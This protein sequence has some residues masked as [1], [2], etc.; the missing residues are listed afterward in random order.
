MKN[1]IVVD[2]NNL[3]NYKLKIITLSPVHIGTGEVYEPTNYIVDDKKLYKFDEIL[4]YKS[5]TKSDKKSFYNKLSNYMQVIDFYKS[6]KEEAK[7]IANFEIITSSKVQNQY[8]KQTNQDGTKNKNQLEIQTTFKNPN[9]N[10]AIIP[11]SSIK[12]MLE[13]AMKI[14]VKPPKPSNETRQNIIISDALLLSGGVEIGYANRRHRDPHKKS[15][16]GIYQIIEVIQPNSEFIF[17]LD[18]NKTFEDIQKMLKNYHKKRDNSRYE[19]TQNSFI[20]KIGKNVAM[21]YVVETDDVSQLRNKDGKPLATHFLYSSDTLQDEQFGWIKIEVISD[22]EY[23][24]ALDNISLQEQKYYQNLEDKQKF[25]KEQ[26]KQEK[27]QA[28]KEAEEKEQKAKEE[29]M[30]KAK[31]EAEEKAR[32]ESMSPLERLIEEQQKQ[33]P[34]I[35]K[36]TLILNG[37]QNG[38]F[39][40]FKCEALSL[41][42]KEM[43][44]SLKWKPKTKAKKPEK[45][46]G[47][48]KTLKVIQMMKDCK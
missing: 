5:L 42:K 41:A 22:E 17:T 35:P 6:K 11:G 20:A 38:I 24:K 9:T 47:Y 31:K 25:I 15:K 28:Q 10:R 12:G 48:Q 29:A 16:D 34:T 18:T 27:E 46:K 26:I 30:L 45:D 43:E 32:L 2:K 8:N 21:D 36:Y 7:S 4:F 3:N 40:E 13:T 37:I 1:N 33:N 39:D 44:N 23:L 19:Q 14:Y